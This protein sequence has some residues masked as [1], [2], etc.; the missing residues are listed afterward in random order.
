MS[1][2]FFI[3]FFFLFI[4]TLIKPV[5]GLFWIPNIKKRSR[6]FALLYLLIAFIVMLVGA[7]SN[8]PTE[9]ERDHKRSVK[10]KLK[11]Y[12]INTSELSEEDI[13]LIYD[14][15]SNKDCVERKLDDIR[16]KYDV[17]PILID[18]DFEFNYHGHVLK[19]SEAFSHDP[20]ASAYDPNDNC[21]DIYGI[22]TK[23]AKLEK[24]V[25]KKILANKLKE[26]RKNATTIDKMLAAYRNSV[27]AANQKYKAKIPP[28]PTDPSTWYFIKNCRI[29]QVTEYSSWGGIT[30]VFAAGNNAFQCKIS[31]D[32]I[33]GGKDEYIAKL[34]TLRN[35]D[36][37]DIRASVDE[38]IMGK[39]S[40]QINLILRG[41]I[42]WE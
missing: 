6:W 4:L 2:L 42:V 5:K 31:G 17:Q 14:S 35:G 9:E 21:S 28:G 25:E 20:N 15:L 11:K 23:L 7:S 30:V 32:N 36:V 38:V 10:L 39:Y 37:V 41:D 8:M 27:L 12:Q 18:G 34:A 33:E 13:E 24:E 3:L 29:A 40:N 19:A 16:K 26:E 22:Q 1:G